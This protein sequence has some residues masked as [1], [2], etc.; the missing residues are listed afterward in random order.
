MCIDENGNG[1]DYVTLTSAGLPEQKTG[2]LREYG[3]GAELRRWI[4]NATK[5]MGKEKKFV[6]AVV[7]RNANTIDLEMALPAFQINPK[8]R[9][10]P[11][12]DLVALEPAGGRWQI[13]FWEAKLVTDPRLRCK[14]KQAPGAR[15]T[16]STTVGH[17]KNN[18]LVACAYKEACELLVA[19]HGLAKR[20]NPEIDE[21]GPGIVAAAAADAHHFYR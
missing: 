3:G 9:T 5:Y 6:D 10:A 15:S 16:L 18:V 12:M 8:E 20:V 11:R 7:A 21:L 4:S 17:L 14:E 13:V 19:F 2:R 1:Q